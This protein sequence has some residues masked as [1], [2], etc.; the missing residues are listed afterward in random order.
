MRRSVPQPPPYLSPRSPSLFASFMHVLEHLPSPPQRLCTCSSLYLMLSLHQ[1]CP[2]HAGILDLGT[3][4]ILDQVILCCEGHS[5]HY[6]MRTSIPG[7]DPLDARR[8]S[9]C[10]W[11]A[12]MPADSTIAENHWPNTYA[13][14]RLLSRC[15]FL[16]RGSMIS[17]I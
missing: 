2:L 9:L 16:G 4:G 11:T 13:S 17:P 14:S 15:H 5:V 7:L 1:F 6:G 3:L 8:T 10:S 12:K